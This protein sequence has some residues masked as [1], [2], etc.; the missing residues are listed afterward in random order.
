[1]IGVGTNVLKA[2]AAMLL[3][4]AGLSV[5]ITPWRAV[6]GRRADLALLRMLG[7]PPRRIAGL[8][9]CEAW[10]LAALATALGLVL[11]HALSLLISRLLQLDHSILTAGWSWPPDLWV[12]PVLALCQAVL[13]ALLPAR[14]AC[15]V[16]VF[17]L[18][19]PR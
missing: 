7:S 15:N 3:L 19:Q 5:F 1:M 17:E 12:V 6:R 16:S 9:L 2:L 14:E 11:G 8:L 4:T 18:L 13:S 10:W